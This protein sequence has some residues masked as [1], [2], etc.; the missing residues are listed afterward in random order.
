MRCFTYDILCKPDDK[1]FVWVEAVPDLD[2]AKVRIKEL[3]SAVGGEY[4]V[5]DRHTLQTVCNKGEQQKKKTQQ[6]A[7]LHS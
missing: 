4:I 1:T 6:P 3:E 2:S 7:P 5:F